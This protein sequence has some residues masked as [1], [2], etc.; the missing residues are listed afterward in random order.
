MKHRGAVLLLL[1][2]HDLA[3]QLVDQC[4]QPVA[5][6]QDWDMLFE[7][8]GRDQRSAVGV[9]AGGA[10]GKDHTA[11]IEVPHR[12]P[13][14][15][16]P[17][18]FGVDVEIPDSAGDKVGVLGPE[19]DDGDPLANALG[20][21]TGHRTQGRRWWQPAGLGAV[22]LLSWPFLLDRVVGGA[23]N[24]I[25]GIIRGTVTVIITTMSGGVQ[26]PDRRFFLGSGPI[27]HSR[28]VRNIDVAGLA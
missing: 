15:G 10:T 7:D 22:C 14:G 16:G 9:N 17:D 3:S 4:L 23:K 18:N 1:A 11:G 19:V 2:R 5:N 8:P 25:P 24:P 28:R 20:S 12:L 27:L 13:G 26:A 21:S 6:P